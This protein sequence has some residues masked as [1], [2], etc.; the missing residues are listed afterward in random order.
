[1]SNSTGIIIIMILLVLIF[2]YSSYAGFSID[3]DQ[4]LNDIL[5]NQDL[6]KGEQYLKLKNKFNWMDAGIYNDVRLLIRENQLNKQNLNVV[7][8]KTVV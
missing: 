7:F 3:K 8:R 1:M 6:F 5:D 2:Q 4:I